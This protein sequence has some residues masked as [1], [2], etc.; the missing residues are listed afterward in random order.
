MFY[1]TI[2]Y[3]RM[4]FLETNDAAAKNEGQE[5]KTSSPPVPRE[6]QEIIDEYMDYGYVIFTTILNVLF[7]NRNKNGVIDGTPDFDFN[8]TNFTNCFED[9]S[10]VFND[11][12]HKLFNIL[13]GAN[14]GSELRTCRLNERVTKN[15]KDPTSGSFDTLKNT[16]H[17]LLNELSDTRK[18]QINRKW[19]ISH[20]AYDHK[21]IPATRTG[22]KAV[23][24]KK[25]LK[26]LKTKFFGRK[27]Y[28][29][30]G[31]GQSTAI[32]E[33]YITPKDGHGIEAICNPKNIKMSN[34]S[35]IKKGSG[36]K[37]LKF[38]CLEFEKKS[39]PETENKR[40]SEN[41][42]EFERYYLTF[43]K[44]ETTPHGLN[45]SKT[46]GIDP[47]LRSRE[48][49]NQINQYI[50]M[51]TDDANSFFLPFSP[52]G[53]GRKL[54]HEA[55]PYRKDSLK[56]TEETEFERTRLNED[57]NMYFNGARFCNEANKEICFKESSQYS[58]PAIISDGQKSVP[59][60]RASFEFFVPSPITK[61][62]VDTLEPLKC[63]FCTY[64]YHNK[65]AKSRRPYNETTKEDQEKSYYEQQKALHDVFKEKV[66]N[67]LT[68]HA[69]RSGGAKRKTKRKHKRRSRHKKKTSNKKKKTRKRKSCRKKIKKKGRLTRKSI[70]RGRT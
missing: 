52:T 19:K 5:S 50:E 6:S 70:K 9:G 36:K 47:V 40:E 35:F 53:S 61:I 60:M 32:Y 64:K 28:F 1:L 30:H 25:K 22:E 7:P 2:I 27:K 41:Q 58:G 23:F 42:E 51:K 46:T 10:F 3:Y 33:R 69:L 21:N 17:M 45:S 13:L 55:Y 39:P 66:A 29:S 43:V 31:P 57:F 18:E 4:S 44:A 12:D 48:R 24:I 56:E 20:L 37:L 62:I 54:T 68:A 16:T 8:S 15:T 49:K 59:F 34:T 14:T 65:Q 26:T 67:A 63:A 38:Y 11:P